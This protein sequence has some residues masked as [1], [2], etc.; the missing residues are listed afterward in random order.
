MHLPP[1]QFGPVR[2]GF[3]VL[4]APM[5]GYTDSAMRTL[6]M[7]QGAG[8]AYSELASSEGLRRDCR[9][10]FLVLETADG[11]HPVAGHL[12]GRDPRA[13][14]DAARAIED[15]GRFDWIDINCGCPVRKVVSRGAGAAL[16][17][18]LPQL[19]KVVEAVKKA[20]SLPV[21]AK[22]RIGF[23]RETPGHLQIAKAIEQSGADMVAVHARYAKNFHAGPADWEK[24]AEIKGELQIPVVGNGGIDRPEDAARMVAATGVD[25][26][27]VGRAAIGNPWIFRQIRHGGGEATLGERREMVAEHLRRLVELNRRKQEQ[28]GGTPRYSPEE[29]ACIQFR[30]H[31]P[32]Y[33]RGL[34]DKKRLLTKLAQLTSVSAILEEVD[35]LVAKNKNRNEQRE[36]HVRMV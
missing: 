26:V 36:P 10:T 23:N 15:S 32:Q 18:D 11:E 4:L 30:P 6:C 28:L 34:F 25:G 31:L 14:A 3:P 19:G 7:E 5:A 17:K 12:F 9:R 29:T 8:A 35:L 13:M 24:L 16:L 22:T 21:S 33:V 20:V 2:I 27:M 1:L